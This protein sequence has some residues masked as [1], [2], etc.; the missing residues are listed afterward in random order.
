MTIFIPLNEV[1]W[2]SFYYRVKKQGIKVRSRYAG[3]YISTQGKKVTFMS[4]CE[5]AGKEKFL[6]RYSFTKEGEKSASDAYRRC[7]EAIP[8]DQLR[9]NIIN[10]KKP[11]KRT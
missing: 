8:K 4:R 2:I 6:G 3:V 10:K 9:R 1:D 7:V 5:I 11:Y